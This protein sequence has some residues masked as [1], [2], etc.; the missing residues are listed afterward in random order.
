MSGGKR[1]SD[2]GKIAGATA[3][4]AI[5]LAGLAAGSHR[6]RARHSTAAIAPAVTLATSVRTTQRSFLPAP[7]AHAVSHSPKLNV[8]RRQVV[9]ELR[10]VG[11]DSPALSPGSRV[12]A[13]QA[14]TALPM[15]FEANNGQ[16]D[17]HVK[18]L[19]HAPGYT[20]LLTDQ[21]AVLSL[22]T[23]SPTP[24]SPHQRAETPLSGHRQTS[25]ATKPARVVRL[26]FVGAATPS[27][28]A[29]R[30]QLPSKT[31][32]FIG[33]DPKQWHTNV[34]NYSAVEYRGIYSGVDAVFH[35]DNRRLEFDFNIA[36][37]ADPH[38]IA[39][40][41]DGARRIRLNRAGDVLLGM[42]GTQDVMMGKP[43]IYQQS[44]AGRREIAGHYVLSARNRIAFALDPYDH[45]QPLVIDPT[46]TYSTYLGGGISQ[47][48]YINAIAVDGSGY[49]YVT[50]TFS[51]DTVPF[52]TTPGS[53]NPGPAPAYGTFSFISKLKTDGSGLV[54]STYFGGVNTYGEG[55]DQIFAIAVDSTGAAY[56]G[57]TSESEDNTPTTP[58]A[59]MPIRPSLYPVAFVAKL[60]ADGSTLVYST[61]LDGSPNSDGDTVGGIAVDSLGSAYVT[62]V[63]TATNFPTKTG[64]FQTVYKASPYLGTAFVTKLSADGSSLVYSTF[65]GGSTGE[66]A[67]SQIGGTAAEGAIA[68]DTSGFAYVTGFTEST[69]FPTTTGAYSTT[70]GSPCQ[71]VFATKVNATGTGLVYST[72]LGGGGAGDKYSVGRSIAVDSAGS[73]FVGGTTNTPTFPVTSGA[74]QTSAGVGFITKLKAD[75]SSQVYSSY[76]GGYVMSVA[77]GSDD[78]AVLFGYSN[79]GYTFEST[80]D[81]FTIPGCASTAGCWY[82]FIS[83]LTADGSALIFSSPIGGDAE[84]CTIAGALDPAGDAYITGSTSSQDLYTTP[85]SFEPS[86][87]SN[88]TGFTPFVAKVAFS[89]ST[90]LTLAPTTLPSG[91]AGVAYSQAITATGGT[92]AVTFAVTTGSLPPGLT[93]TPAGDLAGTPTQT[94]TT[95]FTVT[96]T[97]STNDTGS[98]AYSLQIGCPTITVGPTTLAPGTAGTPYGPVTFTATGAIGTTTFAITT[99][100]LPAGITFIAGVLAG[101]TATQ[102]GSFPFIV[103]VTDSNGCMGTVSDTLTLNPGV[104]TPPAAVTDNETITVTDTET[105]PALVDSETI[106]VTDTDT[107]RAFNAIAITPSPAS[108]N[109]SS[110]TAY[111]TYPYTPVLFTATGGIGTLTLT[112]T[113]ALPSGMTFTGGT[114]SG[115]PSASSAGHTYTFSVTA[116]DADGDQV[117]LLGYTLTVSTSTIPP[118]NVTDPETITVTDTDTFPDVPDAETITVTDTDTVRAFNTIAIAPSAASFNASDG[119]G[120]QGATYG[121]VTFTAMGGTGTLTL[122]ESGT[123]PAGL[124]FTDGVL[125]GTLSS[126]SAG[127]YSFS[128]TA[129]DAD[130]DQATQQGYTLTITAPPPPPSLRI[131]AA[132][133][134]LTIVQGQ[135][136]VTTL[137]FTPAGGYAGTLGLSCSGLPANS[138]CAFSENGVPVDSV[139]LTGNDQPVTVVLTF[140]TDVNI[141][142][143]EMKRTPPASGTIWH[144]IAFWWSGSL[145]GLAALRRNRLMSAKSQRW[146]GLWLLFFTGAMAAGLSGCGGNGGNGGFGTYVTPVGNSTVTVSASPASGAAQTLSIGI[147]IAP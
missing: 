33:N 44:S 143:A 15:S 6:H 101:E 92:G 46:I 19:A 34:P 110:G 62:G 109:A 60:S 85:G 63:T 17:Q 25:G 127:T 80:P 90:P 41:V 114:L 53:Y 87:P 121:P 32:Y 138:L 78:S 24:A 147:T 112:E 97:D 26:K 96:G 18:F 4:G 31:N 93:L 99:D 98:Q 132:P 115:T 118:A 103:T 75:G 141:Q 5:L 16:T 125:G 50:G 129:T 8:P 119:S 61:Y 120:F 37:G 67:V 73:A 117:T 74:L 70:C 82:G 51:A 145:L 42:D 28:I 106:T 130:G 134:S 27:A 107:V 43:H 72:F 56:F 21:E 49:A 23:G 140:E 57:G 111:Q 139:V 77:V 146:L 83:K 89:S 116:T 30:D 12:P 135:T 11:V 100:T 38:A 64:A 47:E 13:M 95:P 126:S 22:P 1:R 136:G 66:N 102:Y 71:D 52:P 58:G 36:P 2:F 20:L 35:G 7:R 55:G 91:T 14:Y 86:L 69:D 3:C 105:F 142:Q 124:T 79:T 131:S 65:L 137:T 68:V 128:V 81:A 144:A 29:G 10:A 45:A 54:Y 59:F 113:G 84:C 108:F 40:E 123:L 76:F 88:Y 133:D 104:S 122:S 48:T 9:P 94:G 39:L